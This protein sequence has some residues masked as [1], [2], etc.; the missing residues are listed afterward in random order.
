MWS[1]VLYMCF[2]GRQE[3]IDRWLVV[4]GRRARSYKKENMSE[5]LKE[6]RMSKQK[7]ICVVGAGVVGLSVAYRIKEEFGNNARVVVVAEAYAQ[8][9]TSYG[10]GGLWLPFQIN[11]T[12]DEMVNRW[13]KISYEFLQSLYHSE[14]GHEAGVQFIAVHQVYEEQ[15]PMPSWKDVP[16]G[17]KELTAPDIVKLG[18]PKKFICGYTFM[19]YVVDQK[20][21]LGWIMKRLRVMGVEF[22]QRKVNSLSEL[23]GY[24]AIVNCTGLGAA[25]LL[26][27]T[28][29]TPIRGQ[30][31]RLRAP[32]MKAVW[33][34]GPMSYII[35]NV[36]NVVVGG[37]AQPGNYDTTVSNADTENILNNVCEVFPSL[38]HAHVE[39]IWA[40]LR[41]GRT[42]LR[43]EVDSASSSTPIVHCYGHGGSGVTLAMGCAEEVVHIHLR[44]L[45]FDKTKYNT[46]SSI[47]L[48]DEAKH[49]SNIL[50]SNLFQPKS[51]L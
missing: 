28:N 14:D 15:R 24:D 48:A 33:F 22:Q 44:A 8:Q 11:G 18:L 16:C 42:S 43:L 45:L 12:P 41:P 9:T 31:L 36:D 39:T 25:T 5:S 46:S 6:P 35:P 1:Q 50:L 20:Y 17:F 29:M 34:L 49:L 26:N 47:A 13:G 7:V 37:T 10:S 27:D 19:T 40:G 38:R 2:D 32:W 21:Y 3:E 51:R 30:V 23:I 4:K